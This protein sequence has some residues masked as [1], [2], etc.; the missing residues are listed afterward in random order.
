MTEEWRPSCSIEALLCRARTLA[1]VRAFF[2]ARDVVE[3]DTPVLS[4]TTV[5]DPAID[6]LSLSGGGSTYYLQTSPEYQ[7]KRLLAAG[8]PSI[9]RIGPVFRAGERGRLHNPEFTM[10]EWYRRGFD[11][12]ALIDEVRAL[13]DT[14]LGVAP[15]SC[16]RYFDL[17]HDAAQIDAWHSSDE[18]LAA[19]LVRLDIEVSSQAVLQRRDRLDLLAEHAL[20]K[21][22]AGRV[23]IIDYPPDQAALACV[24]VDA[25]GRAVARRFE[26]VIDGVEIANGYQEL[27]DADELAARMQRERALRMADGR[28]APDAD[29]RL[30]AALRSGLP[31][32]SGVALGFDRL[33][34]C[35]LGAASI[36]AVLP[37]SLARC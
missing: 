8:A 31:E 6:S 28:A 7:M 13:T 3:V 20:Q 10:L 30:L 37:F 5:T 23:F 35:R 9:F 19:A 1:D 21:L 26:L 15:Y 18:V 36:D 22:G 27:T 33:L 4:Q 29:E 34:M 32:C 16:V 12:T 11:L 25:D 17:L 24:G 2:A 14:V